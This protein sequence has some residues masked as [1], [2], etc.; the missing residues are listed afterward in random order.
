MRRIFWVFL[1]CWLS[2]LP[3]WG[4][5]KSYFHPFVEQVFTF[6][7]NG[8]VLVEERRSFS[9]EGSFSWARLSLLRRGVQDIVFEGV[10]DEETG[11]VCPFE[12]ERSPQEVAIRW[13]YQAQDEVRTFRLRYRLVGVVQRF[14]DVAEFYWKVIE[15]RHAR[16]GELR[17][18]FLLLEKSSELL[19]LFVHTWASPGEMNFSEDWKS[20]SFRLWDIPADTFVEARLLTNPR[21]FSA[22]PPQGERR[23]RA[24]LEEE[25]AFAEQTDRSFSRGLLP[26]AVLGAFWV[27]YLALFLVWHF[28]YGREPRLSYEREYEQEPPRWFPPVF[29]GVLLSQKK[30]LALLVRAFFATIL[31]LARRGYLTVHEEEKRG[32][33]LRRDL[34]S[35]RL[36]AKGEN[37]KEWAK[38]LHP[39]EQE[40]LALLRRIRPSPESPVTTRDIEEWGKTMDGSRGNLVAFLDRWDRELRREVEREYFPLLDTVSERKRNIFIGLGACALIA[41]FVVTF[42]EVQSSGGALIALL[43]PPL[44]LIFLLIV[45]AQHFLSRWSPEAAL[46]YRRLMAFHHFL[47]DFSLLKEASSQLLALWDRYLVYAV[48][49]GVAEKLLRHI[50]RYVEETHI[51]FH[52]PSWYSSAQGTGLGVASPGGLAHFDAFARSMQNMVNLGKALSTSSTSGGGFS[53]GGGGG[54]GG[55]S[56]SAG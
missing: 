45:L 9:F 5:A 42:L 32:F 52:T 46:T 54:G 43:V 21:I 56:S 11:R 30:D 19:K 8:D 41:G 3:S 15:D 23:Y 28:R 50:R 25:R 34:L 20:A 4:W 6:Q 49:L 55:G 33:L 12:V 36:T 39:F 37:D 51:P 31:D 40:V 27:F 13:S 1:T 2:L 14:E 22:V 53:S 47:S 18:I 29:L 10:W 17:S 48:V 24:I 44:A 16:I 38:E 35:F 26:V 7:E